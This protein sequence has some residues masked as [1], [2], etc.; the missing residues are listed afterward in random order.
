M[1]I[2]T[3]FE[4]HL[5]H[6]QYVPAKRVYFLK[7]FRPMKNSPVLLFLLISSFCVTA[8]NEP[9]AIGQWEAIIPFQFGDDLV[10]TPEHIV[11][12]SNEGILLIDKEDFSLDYFSKVNGLSEAGPQH[13][14]YSKTSNVICISYE[15]SNIDLITASGIIEI[16]VLKNATNITGSKSINE[17]VFLDSILY[18]LTDFGVVKFD[19]EALEVKTDLRTNFPVYDLIV[20]QDK[21]LIATENG[22]FYNDADVSDRLFPSLNSWSL[23]EDQNQIPFDESYWHLASGLGKLWMSGG[24]TVI[25][26]IDATFKRDTFQNFIDQF[27]RYLDSD[28]QNGLFYSLCSNDQ[29]EN[30]PLNCNGD[31][32]HINDQLTETVLATDCTDRPTQAL[33]D[34]NRRV[35]ISDR[36]GDFRWLE[37]LDASCNRIRTNTPRDK[38]AYDIAFGENGSLWVAGGSYELT[39]V[40]NFAFRPI[41]YMRLVDGTWEFVS[42]ENDPLL[43]ENTIAAVCNIAIDDARNKVYLA[44]FID[45]LLEIQGDQRTVYNDTDGNLGVDPGDPQRSKVFDVELASNGDLW[46]SN[47]RANRA[48]RVKRADGRWESY[49]SPGSNEL[50]DLVIDDQGYKWFVDAGSSN[51]LVLFDDNG[52]SDPTDDRYRPISASNSSLETNETTFIEKDLDGAIWVGT[53]SGAYLFDCGVSAFENICDGFRPVITVDG[54]PENLLN[55]ERITA[56][57]IDGG[58]RVWLGTTNGVF[59]YDANSFE[60]IA[61]YNEDNSPLLSNA[62]SSIDI[63]KETGEVYIST[64]AGIMRLQTEARQGKEFHESSIKV[65]PNPVLPNYTGPIAIDG[66]AQDS[67]IKITDINGRL[68]FQ[69]TSTGGQAIWDGRDIN[70]NRVK[71]GVYLVF[72]ATTQGL[73]SSGAV[74]KVLVIPGQR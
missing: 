53:S 34:E 8:Q 2:K 19:A 11:Y 15:N 41:T 72:A 54:L 20:F 27:V 64:L 70:G 58:N 23:L 3:S 48:I 51:A 37:S 39:N 60:E 7:S 29:D 14:A 6:G 42:W 62:I 66:F 67:D 69:T 68:V 36:F 43:N 10:E 31:V 25:E 40:E 28:G 49:I 33:I 52:T 18:I 22:I 71:S 35:W 46:M 50:T 24:R 5:S 45:G 16:P 55:D 38:Q 1:L 57:D 47:F 73:E 21:L 30:D 17:L 65:Y 44:S 61:H 59:V 74:A 13:I 63:Q 12:C 32:F 4:I 56:L 26:N 9:L